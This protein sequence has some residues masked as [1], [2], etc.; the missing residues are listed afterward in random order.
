MSPLFMTCIYGACVIVI[1]YLAVRMF[2]SV[3]YTPG[4]TTIYNSPIAQTLF[5]NEP[6][7]LS[8]SW[9][10]TEAGTL[11]LDPTKYGQGD[12][13]P[14]SGKGYE[15][16]AIASGGASPSGGMRSGGSGPRSVPIGAWNGDITYPTTTITSIY[17]DESIPQT[18]I[19]DIGWWGKE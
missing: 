18:T 6:H 10:Y 17:D 8:P 4:V 15:P 9:G 16:T 13:W 2:Y 1:L 14:E 7:K 3:E 12:F 11:K 19:S 5:P